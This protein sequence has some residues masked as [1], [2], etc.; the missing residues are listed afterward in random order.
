MLAK[1]IHKIESIIDIASIVHDLPHGR[2]FLFRGQNVNEPPLPRFAR[3]VRKRNL[4]AE[5]VFKT[6]RRMLDRFKKE[7]F[8]FLQNL[9]PDT[10]FDWLSIAQHYGL[11]TRLLDWTGNALAALWF[12]VASDPGSGVT[13]GVV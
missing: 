3:E 10:D 1:T 9:R 6:E 5:E 7:S 2:R 11:P 13:E 8:P 12:A 4:S